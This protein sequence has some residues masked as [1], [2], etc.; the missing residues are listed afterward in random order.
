MLR[1]VGGPPRADRRHPGHPLVLRLR[2]DRAD[3]GR[4]DRGRHRRR[5]A[6]DRRGC[7]AAA[8]P[9]RPRPAPHRAL[10]RLGG[11]PAE[12]RFRLFAALRAAGRG[13]AR[14][15]AAVHAGAGSA[16]RCHRAGRGRRARR[17][18]GVAAA[19]GAAG[20]C[21]RR[22]GP[23][24]ADLLA[25]HPAHHRL[26]GHAGLAAGGRHGRS[27]AR[28]LPYLVLPVATLA[29][30]H[31]AAY[32]RHSAASLEADAA[33]NPGSAPRARAAPGSARVL[34]RHAFPNAALPG[35]ADRRTGCRRAGRRR[36]GHG[37][38]SSPGPAWASCST[39]R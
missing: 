19:R 30:A 11:R 28:A 18:G 29:I 36:A 2:A 15:G 25:R 1:L 22:H 8:R 7:R 38:A 35:A 17:A 14:A 12:G 21:H 32:A 26:R 34:L 13:A 27:R 33:P 23:V 24:D 10:P 37:D 6:P 5:P 20:R 9:A 3:A 16:R 4:P 39:T 31:L